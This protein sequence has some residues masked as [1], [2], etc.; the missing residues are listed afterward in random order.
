MK[1]YGIDI[2]METLKGFEREGLTKDVNRSQVFSIILDFIA[3][4]F[5]V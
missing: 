2:P 1:Y 4:L 5:E 3:E